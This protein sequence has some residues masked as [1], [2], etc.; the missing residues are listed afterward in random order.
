M[1][2]KTI[3]Q[4]FNDGVLKVYKIS[5]ISNKGDKPKDGLKAKYTNAIPYEERTVGI[6]RNH[7]AKQDQSSIEQLVRIPRLEIS[8][9]DV[10]ILNG[11]QYD[12]YQS[13]NINNVEPR[14]L[15]LSLERLETAY[16]VV[17]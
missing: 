10:V 16:E 12:I 14:C 2:P 3:T 17:E 6:T 5:N 7:L 9:H 11:K 15:D 1:R 13:Q 4:T 8:V